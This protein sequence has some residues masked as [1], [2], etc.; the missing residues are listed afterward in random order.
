MSRYNLI[1]PFCRKKQLM[2]M[3][4]SGVHCAHTMSICVCSHTQGSIS[5][6]MPNESWSSFGVFG[7]FSVASISVL[8][9]EEL[10]MRQWDM[11]SKLSKSCFRFVRKPIFLCCKHEEGSGG[12]GAEVPLWVCSGVCASLP[13]PEVGS[14]WPFS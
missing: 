1:L 12:R 13:T 2:G 5:V 7:L 8:S 3:K 4:V 9:L 10:T 11:L 14:G 6:R